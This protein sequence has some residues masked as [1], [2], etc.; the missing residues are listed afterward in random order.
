MNVSLAMIV[1]DAESSL[2]ACLQSVAGH[3]DEIVIVDTGSSDRTKEIAA[4]FT[5]RILEF[6]WCKDFSG[7]SWVAKANK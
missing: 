1:K 6:A 5:D 2:E 7:R 3:V 4:Q